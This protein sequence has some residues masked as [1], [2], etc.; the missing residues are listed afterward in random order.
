MNRRG[1]RVLT[2]KAAVLSAM[3]AGAGMA[4]A[5]DAPAIDHAALEETVWKILQG[6]YGNLDASV[7]DSTKGMDGM[8]A[9][10]INY[11]ANGTGTLSTN[12]KGANIYGGSGATP[13]GRVGWQPA[14]STNASTIGWRGS[15]AIAGMDTKFLIQVEAQIALTESPGI[16]TNYTAQTNGIRGGLG[17][18]TT[19]IGFGGK[20]WGAVKLG[21]SQSPYKKATDRLDPFTGMVGDM[22]VIMGNTGGD[23]RV[24]FNSAF[25]HAIWYE[26]PK[27]D[28]FSFDFMFSPGQNRTA[29]EN[30]NLAGGS[31]NCN[32]GNIP[33]SG[34]LLNICDDGGFDNAF[35][36]AFKF[37]AKDF[38]LTAAYELHKNVN[39]NSDGIGSNH[40]MYNVWFGEGDPTAGGGGPDSQYLN[41]GL[42]NAVA[43][44]Y[45]AT[46]SCASAPSSG[47]YYCANATPAFIGDIGDEAA[48]KIG[49]QYVTPFGLTV[50]AIVE[51]MTR[52]IPAALQWQNERQRNGWWL[53]F[54]QTVS[55]SD[56]L[57]FGW[58]HAGRTPGDPGGQHNY[59]PTNSNDSADM[60]TLAWKHV[61]D[62][63]L[64]VYLDLAETVNHGN[65]HYDLGGGGHGIKTDC[66]DGTTQ[67]IIDY[68][69]AG[70]TTWGGCKPKALSIGVNYKF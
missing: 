33:G 67:P 8:V 54:T 31:S 55:A 61:L 12:P 39:R 11:N 47:T 26:S 27:M 20:D 29:D 58:A 35:S 21:H 9:Y 30:L 51:R 4:S 22:P 2:I 56:N 36:L 59:D 19:F 45:G 14:I 41:W 63:Q 40:P 69:S 17:S 60:F 32:G 16:V 57:N 42:Y 34:N 65:A 10:H 43:T 66:H 70:N 52:K 62:K 38:Y 15:H 6:F 7:D 44:A 28:G 5:A 37:E 23:N 3:L 13:Y 53:A 24:E 48:Y 18:G 64:F 25:D 50:D 46:G 1:M 68:T 49:A